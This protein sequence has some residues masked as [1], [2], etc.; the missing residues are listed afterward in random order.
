MSVPHVPWLRAPHARRRNALPRYAL[1]SA[2]AAMDTKSLQEV[3]QTMGLPPWAALRD[4]ERPGWANQVGAASH[5][6]VSLL[7]TH[8]ALKAEETS[9]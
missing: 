6:L 2:A 7:L 5:N 1:R 3:L 9:A 8:S 4:I